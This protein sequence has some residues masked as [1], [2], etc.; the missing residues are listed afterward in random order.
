MTSHR[1]T[2][3]VTEADLRNG[4]KMT[5]GEWLSATKIY[6]RDGP[7]RVH[8][9]TKPVR[10]TWFDRDDRTR[11]A[12]TCRRAPQLFRVFET[13]ARARGTV[14]AL[15]WS[16][17]K[18]G[19]GSL[20]LLNHALRTPAVR[21]GGLNIVRHWLESRQ[22]GMVALGCDFL[23]LLSFLEIRPLFAQM[24]DSKKVNAEYYV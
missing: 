20:Y 12:E 13:V 15:T 22:G 14:T 18:L 17:A 10:V 21:K 19:P 24:A 5:A 6:D 3:H 16:G 7:S 11:H 9:L 23:S 1:H 2:V 4:R 8:D